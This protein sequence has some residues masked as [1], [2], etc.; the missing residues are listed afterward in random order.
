MD[1]VA[2]VAFA[3]W[4]QHYE[5]PDEMPFLQGTQELWILQP[6]VLSFAHSKPRPSSIE[7]ANAHGL[8]FQN[9]FT[10]TIQCP[11]SSDCLALV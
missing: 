8:P 9:S 3:A 1:Q 7:K 10:L 6:L 5:C 4:G 2:L 11:E